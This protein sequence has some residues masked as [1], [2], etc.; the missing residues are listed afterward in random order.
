MGVDVVDWFE[1]SDHH[2]YRPRE[3]LHLSEQARAKGRDGAADHREGCGEPV[4]IVATSC[5]P[6]CRSSG[7]KV[8]LEIERESE[9]VDELE[10]RIRP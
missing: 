5:W 9:F 7:S 8:R 6:R 10:R 1:Y 4:R 2:R 3:L